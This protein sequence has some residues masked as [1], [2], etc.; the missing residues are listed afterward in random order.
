[1]HLEA[2]FQ[3]APN[4]LLLTICQH[5]VIANFFDVVLFLLSNLVTGP[6]FMIISSPAPEL[7][8]FT[9]IRGLPGI[10]KLE[11]PPSEFCPISGDWERVRDNKFETV[12]SSEILLNAAKCQ[13][14]NF[15]RFR[16][17]KGKPTGGV[18]GGK[19]TPSPHPTQIKTKQCQLKVTEKKE[20]LNVSFAEPS[21]VKRLTFPVS[22][23]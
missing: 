10:R 16:V 19:I 14:C 23:C 22:L 12:V 21:E 13:G 9:F 2:G 15:Y 6:S 20:H 1:M 5:D 4:W 18:G 8:Q 3:I 17:F 11:I 7:W